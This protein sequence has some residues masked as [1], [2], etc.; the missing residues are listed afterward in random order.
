MCTRIRVSI[1]VVIF[2][3]VFVKTTTNMIMTTT[4][5]DKKIFE[6]KILHFGCVFLKMI[7]ENIFQ[8]KQFVR[9]EM[10]SYIF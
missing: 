8:H 6:K 7:L 2:F 4:I 10:K 1:V 3:V 5:I 9:E